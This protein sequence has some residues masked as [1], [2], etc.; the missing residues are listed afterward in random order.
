MNKQNGMTIIVKTISR[1]ILWMILLYGTYI[2]LHGHLTPGGGFGGGV[3]LAL[4]LLS[5]LLAYG[6]DFTIKWL[7]FK[8]LHTLESTSVLLFLIVGIIGL[9]IGKVFLLNFLP[10]GEL[11]HLVSSGTIPVLNI[12]IGLK[13]G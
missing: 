8:W 2:I 10:K 12:I 9:L 5:M 13:V 11:F 7:N 6:R 1:I 4:G 3:V